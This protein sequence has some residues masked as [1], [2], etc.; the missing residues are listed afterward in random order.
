MEAGASLRGE[1]PTGGKR[2]RRWVLVLAS[3]ASGVALLVLAAT[4]AIYAERR[5]I[6]ASFVRQYLAAYGIESEIEFD[7]LA[8][9]GFLA[10]VRAGSVDAPDFIAEGVDV[11]LIYPDTSSYVAR[12]TPQVAAMRLVRPIMRV[13]YD[14]QKLSFGSLQ[15]LV[16]DIL[17]MESDVPSP[18]IAIDDGRLL[19]STPYGAVV[20]MAD[21]AIDKNKLVRLNATIER[22]TLKDGSLVAEITDGTVTAAIAGEAVNAKAS[23]TLTSLTHG[24]RTAR[25][26]DLSAEARGLKWQENAGSYKFS[27][28][29]AVLTI[30]TGNAEAPEFST[31]RTSARVAL[32]ATEGSWEGEQLHLT[33]HG[34]VS[35]EAGE[36]RTAGAEAT[37]LKMEGSLSAFSLDASSAQWSADTTA[38]VVLDA[39]GARYPLAS[40]AV[41]LASMHTE[42]DS[43]AKLDMGGAA[44]RF[45][46]TF[47][48]NGTL[49]ERIALRSLRADFDGEMANGSSR[50]LVSSLTANTSVPRAQ[51]LSL[52]REIPTV[53]SDEALASSIAAAFQNTTVRLRSVGLAMSD[54]GVAVTARAPIVIEGA[55]KAN[56]TL[57]PRGATPLVRTAGAQ[58]TGGFNLNVSGGGLPQVRLA[59]ASYRH[60]IARDRT[61][62]DADAEFETALSYGSFRGIDLSGK[63]KLQMAGDRVRFDGAECADLTLASYTAAGA[64]LVRN[65]NG[66]FCGTAIEMSGDRLQLDLANCADVNFEAFRNGGA[67]QL[68]DVR[69]RLCAVPNRPLLASQPSGWQLEVNL[70]NAVARLVAGEV[71][72]SEGAARVQLSGDAAAIRGGAITL[73]RANIADL[74][75]MPRFQPISLNGPVRING[76]DWSG[77]F[78][79]SFRERR[80]ASVALKHTLTSGTGEA[81]I[82]A[83]GVAFEPNMLQP[84]DIAPFLSS[85]GTRIRGYVDFTGRF[86]WTKDGMV[87]EGRLVLPGIDLQSPFGAVRQ[88]KTELAFTSLMPLGLR[89]AQTVTAD[90]IDVAV[91]LEQVSATFTYTPEA[92]RL[93]AATA[94]VAQG[95]ATLDPMTYSFAAGAT[96][97]GTLRLQNVNAQTLIE[98]AGL[99]DRMSLQARIDGTV[100]FTL[101]LEGARFANGRIAANA[102]GRLSIKREALTTSVGTGAGGQVPPNAVQDFAYQALEHLAFERLEGVV[103]SQPMGRLGLLLHVIG[104]NDPPQVAETRVGVIDLLRGRAFDKPLPLPKGTPIDLTLDTSVNLDELLASYLNRSGA[105]AATA[106][107]N[108]VR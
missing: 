17:S 40:G 2:R 101:G 26:V 58:T 89:P 54:Q 76:D 12:V 1:R 100:P 103:N 66:R 28:D 46:G 79:L 20:V 70:N 56:L 49:P 48:A 105:P 13:A 57:S 36:L 92:L 5:L 16:D 19:L 86:S 68:R 73:D 65:L 60:R 35:G 84:A 97:S 45:K 43:S 62:L 74:Q 78:V 64:D 39:S 71:L 41:T 72:V 27:I 31:S 81:V 24:E 18:E 38:R 91:P 55:E 3:I 52:A 83:R 94:V 82:T 44:G 67:D 59:V 104:Q 9:G 50:L 4:V 87:S 61:M 51:A 77:D 25:G 63:G 8:W 10:R 21:V 11:T 53:G 37:V 85:F 7:R 6:A 75:T 88:L 33:G 30:G 95:R 80:L 99:T 90:R 47:A 107:G 29:N 32:Q 96:S 22:G 42:F 69:G 108:A 93:E 23:L 102:P 15:R 106:P 98:V 14:G 34:I